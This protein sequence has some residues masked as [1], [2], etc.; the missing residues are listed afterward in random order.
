M[1]RRRTSCSAPPTLVSTTVTATPRARSRAARSDEWPG[2]AN[3]IS[4]V[5]HVAL[6]RLRA[7]CAVGSSRSPLAYAVAL[8]RA[9][10]RAVAARASAARVGT[11]GALKADRVLSSSRATWQHFASRSVPPLQ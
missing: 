11:G 8:W 10:S 4:A 2:P 5:A 6:P 9:A 3:T 1:P 7:R